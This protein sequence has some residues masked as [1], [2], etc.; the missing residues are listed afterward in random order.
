MKGNKVIR[1]NHV[2]D[3]G[4]PFG[5]LIERLEDLESEGVQPSDA[6]ADLGLFYRDARTSFD[7]DKNFRE[8]ARKRVVALQ[9][10]DEATMVRWKQLVDISFSY[11]DEVYD[12]LGVLLTKDDVRGESF[13]DPLLGSVVERLGEQKALLKNESGAEV[14]YPGDWLNREGNPLPLIIKK[15]RWRLQLRHFGLSLHNR[16]NREA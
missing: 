12:L 9:S 1:E 8:R 15:G 10:G 11:F 14:M 7:T 3:W 16:P 6:L 5:M 2:G 4:T 13:Y